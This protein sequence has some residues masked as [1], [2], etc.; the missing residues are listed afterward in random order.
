MQFQAIPQ[1]ANQTL[2]TRRALSPLRLPSLLMTLPTNTN[3]LI[4]VFTWMT[5]ASMNSIFLAPFVRRGTT[6]VSASEAVR[7]D[8]MHA[9]T[10]PLSCSS[11]YLVAAKN[12]PCRQRSTFPTGF[13]ISPA[14][15]LCRPVPC[16]ATL[17][18]FLYRRCTELSAKSASAVKGFTAT[19]TTTANTTLS[20]ASTQPCRGLAPRRTYLSTYHHTSERMLYF[21]VCEV[22]CCLT[23]FRVR[24]SKIV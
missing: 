1:E 8:A 2:C 19:S 14:R 21:G 20:A 22:H 6:P 18:C 17:P 15:R 16:H 10:P 5:F 9:V 11:G 7:P 3:S 4:C 24:R 12:C 13:A 23:V